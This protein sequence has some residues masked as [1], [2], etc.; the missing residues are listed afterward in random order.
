MTKSESIANLAKALVAFQAEM[1]TVAFDANNPFF[2]SKYAT[3]S[4]LV[5][6]SKPF[7]AK[8]KLAVSQLTEGEG[9]VITVLLHES[10]EYMEST[11]NLK[12]VKDDPQGRGS[13]ITYARRYAYASILGLVSDQDDDGNVASAPQTK[14][15]TKPASD[16]E[17]AIAFVAGAKTEKA[18]MDALERVQS[19]DKFTDEQKK[20]LESKI[21]SRIDEIAQPA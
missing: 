20:E 14:K 2:K 16:Y 3:L 9:G 10:G 15:A 17:K 7:L 12:P 4:A 18:L 6:K 1:G 19:S 21:S 8:H 11:L 5:E 13:A